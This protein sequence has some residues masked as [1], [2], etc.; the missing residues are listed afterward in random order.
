MH[1][2]G[3]VCACLGL[4]HGDGNRSSL[5]ASYCVCTDRVNVGG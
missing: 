3:S 2:T 4:G 1:V 5:D